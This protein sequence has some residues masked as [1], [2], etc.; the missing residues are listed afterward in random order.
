M[1]FY[2]T[3]KELKKKFE[4]KIEVYQTP[5][6]YS[7]AEAS[8]LWIIRG[9]IEYFDKLDIDFL[10]VENESGIPSMKADYFANNT[11]R[12]INS[13]DNLAGLWKMKIEKP[14]ELKFLL[15]IRTL[16]VHS[17]EL[18]NKVESLRLE[19]YKDNQL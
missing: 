16:I 11:Y 14:D 13:I 1:Q 3:V 6:T 8:L 10:G 9:S 19:G 2:G 18:L 15:D 4:E 5:T 7:N 17:G 12:L